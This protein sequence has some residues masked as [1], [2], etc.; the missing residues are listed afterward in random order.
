VDAHRNHG[1]TGSW[2]AP[3][4]FEP[5]LVPRVWGGSRLQ[6][7]FGKPPGA[8]PRIGESW[9]V[10]D[11]ADAESVLEGGHRLND[12]WRNHRRQ[13]FGQRGA[14]SGSDRFPLLIK[15]LDAREALSI[16]V[17]P[18]AHLAAGLGG[19][20]KSEVWFFL[21][22]EPGAFV[23]AGV[24][25]GVTQ[26]RFADALANGEDVSA[27]L[28]RLEVSAGTALYL[29]SGRVHAIGPGCLIAE[30]QQSS[31][32]TYRVYDY[33][34]PGL[35][36]RPRDLH[37]EE[38]LKCIDF[39]DVRPPLL[40][41]A[42]ADAVRTP[43]F[44]VERVT[45]KSGESVQP[46]PPGEGAIVGVVRG[47]AVCGSRPLRRGV[48]YLV[49]ADAPVITATDDLEILRIMLPGTTDD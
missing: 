38:S 6:D 26:E 9:E 17:H 36:G 22:N 40:K 30:I 5:L 33:D 47:E 20:P 39:D 19:E 34:R 48:F 28:H 31:D 2:N 49:P 18:P 8:E 23:Y 24:E 4:A 16:Q 15:L 42:E 12:L 35:D 14:A 29:P 37:V 32:T 3:L 44:E 45:L 25:P 13:V 41:D 1:V 11:R 21:D 10:V 46:A 43:Y 7:V 27:L